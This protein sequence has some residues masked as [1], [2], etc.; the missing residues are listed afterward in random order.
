ML[1]RFALIAGLSMQD[2]VKWLP[3]CC[4]AK[5]YIESKLREHI[6]KDAE[7]S[8]LIAAASA[9]SFYKYTLYRSAGDSTESFSIGDVNIR[10]NNKQSVAN[11]GILYTNAIAEIFD[12]LRDDEFY[13]KQVDVI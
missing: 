1:N 9:L 2:A 6:D 4:E 8:R 10:S 13:F 7:S 12:L 11:A 3:V 5:T